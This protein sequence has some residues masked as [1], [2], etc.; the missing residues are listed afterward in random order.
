MKNAK[1]KGIPICLYCG[2]MTLMCECEDLDPGEGVVWAM[3]TTPLTYEERDKNY[4]KFVKRMR[5]MKTAFP[6]ENHYRYIFLFF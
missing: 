2:Q 4:N 3:R 5:A 6:I 1:E